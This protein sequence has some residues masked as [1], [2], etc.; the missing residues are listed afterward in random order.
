MEPLGLTVVS[1]A[2]GGRTAKVVL[3]RL[4]RGRFREA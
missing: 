1:K 3:D 2:G 4:S